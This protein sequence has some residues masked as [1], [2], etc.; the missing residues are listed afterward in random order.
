MEE[1]LSMA[2]QM[3]N[4]PQP[5]DLAQISDSSNLRNGSVRNLMSSLDRPAG[6]FDQRSVDSQKTRDSGIRLLDN[7]DIESLIQASKASSRLHA[8]MPRMHQHLFVCFCFVTLSHSLSP[9]GILLI[10]S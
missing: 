1:Q 2:D 10:K 3:N 7:D 4:F 8:E 9:L 5:S 6:E